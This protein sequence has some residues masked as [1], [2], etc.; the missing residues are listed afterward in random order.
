M[1]DGA[2][3]LAAADH[4]LL[5]LARRLALPPGTVGC[6]HPVPVDGVPAI[7]LSFALPTGA[8]DGPGAA[9]RLREQL[10]AL[11]Q[12][13]PGAALGDWRHGPDP[14]ARAAAGAAAAGAARHGG[15][16]VLFP[17]AER[18]TGTVRVAEVLAQSAVEEVTVLGS[19]G[20]PDEG[21]EVV[22]RDHVR[23]VWHHGRLRLPLV[24]AAG[25]RLTPFEVPDPTPCCA[26]HF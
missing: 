9:A 22:T 1:A 11:G 6:T 25:G 4:L 17:G 18:L 26:D 16:A 24:P 14:L 21:T 20:P 7:A 5:D 12:D 8:A 19:P 10:S 13:G 23:P 15:R 2:P 3:D